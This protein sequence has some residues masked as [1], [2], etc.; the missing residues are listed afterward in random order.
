MHRDRFPLSLAAE[1]PVVADSVGSPGLDQGSDKQQQ[2]REK[3]TVQDT[4]EARDPCF[5][6]KLFM[7]VKSQ[8]LNI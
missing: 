1:L 5:L 4:Y 7:L 2:S 6:Y 8:E 3:V